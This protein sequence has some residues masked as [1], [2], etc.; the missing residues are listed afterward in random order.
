MSSVNAVNPNN[1]DIQLDKSG[2]KPNQELDKNAFMQLLVTQLQYQ[3][4]LNP[5][6]NQQMMAQMAQFTALEQM[7]N[8]SNTVEKQLAHSLIGQFVEY[9]YTNPETQKTD[10]LLGKVDYIKTSG[11]N[12]YIGIGENEVTMKDIMQVVDASNIQANTSPFDLIGK[13]VQA[14][15]EGKI[16][17]KPDTDTDTDTNK[18]PD[19]KAG[20]KAI[21]E[22]EVLG[23]VMKEGNPYVVLGT[24]EHKMEIEFKKVQNVVEKPSITGK[25]VTATIKDKDGNEVKIEGIAEYV[26]IL[27][28]EQYVYVSGQF[29][30]LDDIGY[31]TQASK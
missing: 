22:G 11:G 15:V 12:T 30:A 31:I 18:V 25:H 19:I 27:K 21:V 14:V 7:M 5:M 29:V 28:N 23:V 2:K 10:Y 4:P 13:T 24:G 26:T 9:Q 20:E 16:P 6:D 8:V 3:D 17:G 1:K